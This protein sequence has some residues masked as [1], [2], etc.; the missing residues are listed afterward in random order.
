MDSA[1]S[2]VLG[3]AIKPE[4]VPSG[5]GWLSLR[6]VHVDAR[7][8]FGGLQCYGGTSAA[9]GAAVLDCVRRG[10]GIRATGCHIAGEIRDV[11]R[12]RDERDRIGRIRHHRLHLPNADHQRDQRKDQK[13]SDG[14][15]QVRHGRGEARCIWYDTYRQRT[16]RLVQH[17]S[18]YFYIL[19][20]FSHTLAWVWTYTPDSVWGHWRAALVTPPSVLTCPAPPTAGRR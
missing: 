4:C 10:F 6:V 13:L 15:A 19:Q 16:M 18:T 8:R 12:H 17:I 11:V 3:G 1:R 9:P 2:G 20:T 14:R 5:E 7:Q